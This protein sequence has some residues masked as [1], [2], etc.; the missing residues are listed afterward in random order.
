MVDIDEEQ[1]PVKRKGHSMA[2]Y[3][4]YLIIFGGIC[5]ITKEMNDCWAFNTSSCQYTQLFGNDNNRGS[6]INSPS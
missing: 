2:L 1:R 6:P 4:N 5:E 3:K